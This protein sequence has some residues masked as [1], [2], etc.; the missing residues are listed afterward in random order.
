MRL[1]WYYSYYLPVQDGVEPIDI[2]CAWL[3]NYKGL[4]VGGAWTHNSII[5]WVNLAKKYNMKCH[6][7]RVS[8][9]KNMIFCERADVNSI[10]S[11]TFVQNPGY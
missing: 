2:D 3:R 9:L 5:G 6:V 7:G 11:T 10:D 8:S 1:P 4:F